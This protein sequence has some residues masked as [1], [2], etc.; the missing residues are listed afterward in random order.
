M[1]RL[2]GFPASNKWG[3]GMRD[4]SGQMA[5]EL[6]VVLPVLIIVMVIAADCLVF[7][8]ECARFDH[9]A[10]QQVLA[11]ATSPTSDENADGARA[12][13]VQSALA[14][15]F[16]GKSEVVSVETSEVSEF[17]GVRQVEYRCRLSMT[18]WPFTPSSGASVFGLQIPTLLSHTNSLVISPYT[19]GEL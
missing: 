8:G 5:V 1:N 12:A 6:V 15:E 3:A 14:D 19:T 10:S 11:H 7:A 18:P 9:I 16:N 17:M 13:A 2:A 4:C